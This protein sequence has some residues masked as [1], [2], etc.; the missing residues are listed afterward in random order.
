M[1]DRVAF[2]TRAKAIMKEHYWKVFFACLIASLLGATSNSSSVNWNIDTD[3]LAEVISTRISFSSLLH[4]FSIPTLLFSS[5]VL[6]LIIIVSLIALVIGFALSCF[7]F[8]ILRVGFCRYLVLTQQYG[9]PADMGEIFWGFNCGHYM[10]LVKTMFFCNLHIFLWSLLFIIPGIIKAYEY[11][12]VPYILAQ[13]PDMD[14]R[15][16]LAYSKSMTDGHKFDIFV[17]KLSFIGWYLLGGL[18]FGIGGIFVT[19]YAEL[20]NAE[21]YAFLRRRIFFDQTTGSSGPNHQDPY[22]NS[23]QNNYQDNYQNY[24]QGYTD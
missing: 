4:N 16:V 1:W 18:L 11:T 14:Y 2:K 17:L 19:P 23:Y 7:V 22:Q 5:A 12:C 8:S 13:H 10:N 3:A 21:M 9:R 20:T 15:E 24:S 6:I